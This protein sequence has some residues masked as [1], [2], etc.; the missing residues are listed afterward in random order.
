[1]LV[2][3]TSNHPE[4]LDPALLHRPSRFDR[5][6]RFCLPNR[7]QRLELLKKKGGRYFSTVALERAAKVSNGFSMAYVQEIIVN[8]LLDCAHNRRVADDDDL[9][10]SLEALKVQRKK[11][12]KAEEDIADRESIGFVPVGAQRPTYMPHHVGM[13]EKELDD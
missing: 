2:I 1:M 8:A 13:F 10:R 6:W 3:A 12:S 7:T 5:I 11:A 4:D 9:F